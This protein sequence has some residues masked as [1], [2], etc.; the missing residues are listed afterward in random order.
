MQVKTIMVSYLTAE[1]SIYQGDY[2]G[3]NMVKK[4]LNSLLVGMSSNSAFMKS[5]LMILQ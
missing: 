1:N 3:S 2:I 5:S 4:N